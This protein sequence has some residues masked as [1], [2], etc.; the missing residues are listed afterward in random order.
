M[1]FASPAQIE[2]AGRLEFQAA[3][4]RRAA[5]DLYCCS[6]STEWTGYAAAAYA[7][8]AMAV[9]QR[10]LAA[11]GQIDTAAAAVRA[12]ANSPVAVGP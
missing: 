8:E 2:L 12:H 5:A 7:D 3:L 1:S 9:R 6:T 10:L 11:A 4:L